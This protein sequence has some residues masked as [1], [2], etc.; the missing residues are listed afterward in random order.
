MAKKLYATF[1]LPAPNGCNLQC[2]FCAIAQRGE[3]SK[4]YLSEGDYVRF[5]LD[6][7]V[8]LQVHRVSIQGYEPLL[9]EVWHL[10]S[11]LLKLACA[12]MCET[13]LVTNGIHLAQYSTELAEF[14]DSITVSMDS[15]N[16]SIHDRLRGKIGA[17]ASTFAGI[18]TAL[19]VFGS[20]AL[21]VNSVLLPSKTEYLSGMPELLKELGVT[22]WIISPMISFRKESYLS[23]HEFIKKTILD[24]SDQAT[25]LGITVALSD[26]LRT[27][28]GTEL[29]ETLSVRSLEASDEVFRLSPDGT[30]SRGREILGLSKLA[31]QWDKVTQP[32][33]FLKEVFAEVHRPL[34]ERGRW[35]R[36]LLQKYGSCVAVT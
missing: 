6:A 34:G 11:K 8:N 4:P 28:E 23:E 30:C 33:V 36:L 29:F 5:L 14:T 2:S 24:F 18:R 21:S 9:P 31:P 32:H 3:A 25:A 13:S 35:A 12:L 7:L 27:T 15:A 20:K 17:H 22:E 26:E 19:G 1:V 16:A 10:T